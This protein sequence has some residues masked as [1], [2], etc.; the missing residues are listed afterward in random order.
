MIK[1]TKVSTNLQIKLLPY[2]K[3]IYYSTWRFLSLDH[4]F[5]DFFDVIQVSTHTK[6]ECLYLQMDCQTKVRSL[7]TRGPEKRIT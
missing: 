5:I 2:S 1:K 3:E 7:N 6:D 4:V